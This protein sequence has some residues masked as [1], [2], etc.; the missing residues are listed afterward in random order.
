MKKFFSS[1]VVA[2][3]L[4]FIAVIG[5]V[6]INTRVRL[7]KQCDA[8]ID[9]FYSQPYSN[10][11]SIADSLQTLCNASEQIVLLG[12]KYEVEDAEDA[13]RFIDPIRDAIRVRSCHAE[14]IYRDYQQLLKATF[15][16]ESMLARMQLSD[17]DE[18]S[19]AN[20]QRSA[21]SAKVGIDASTYNDNVR[22]FLKYNG[23]FPTPQIAALSGVSMPEL[24]A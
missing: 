8:L 6:I 14:G 7:G 24:F 21:A 4:A 20:A 15:S 1:P 17:S 10:E 18:E 22:S 16:M 13:V 3:I 11:V 23:R 2:L 5:S 19:Y 12:V 9:C